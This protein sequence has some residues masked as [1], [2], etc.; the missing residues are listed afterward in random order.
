MHRR[1][2][3][4]RRY[5]SDV[6][7]KA[8]AGAFVPGPRLGLFAAFVLAACGGATQDA[9]TP[10][11][12]SDPAKESIGQ[13]AM[14]QGGLSMLGGAGNRDESTGTEVAF[15]G[16]LRLE[17]LSKKSPPKLDGLL[18]EW[19]A[20]TPAKETIAGNVDSLGLD[21]AVQAGDDTLWLAAEITDAKL[22]R[23]PKYADN[24]DHVTLVLAF[25]SGRGALKAYEIGFWPGV[26]GP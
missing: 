6:Q 17:T 2:V 5:G 9:K 14:E 15:A 26:A 25:P 16:P 24:E 3:P 8:H 21:V 11:S 20:R 4:V 12:S 1:K 13:A 18:K 19:H 23:S 7:L 10:A 22:V